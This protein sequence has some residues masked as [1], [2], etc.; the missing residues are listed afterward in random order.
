MVHPDWL[1]K[2]VREKEDRFRQRKLVDIFSRV[3]EDETTMQDEGNVGD[4]EDLVS[5][6]DVSNAGPRPVVH[7]LKL[8]KKTIHLSSP[9]QK[10]E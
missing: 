1:H 5:K 2:K 4:T 10:L 7:F 9:V 6:K 8:T 3:N